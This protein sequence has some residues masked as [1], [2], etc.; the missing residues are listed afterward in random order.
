MCRSS[1]VGNSNDS[2]HV[3]PESGIAADLHTYD[4]AANKWEKF[5]VEAALAELS[6]EEAQVSGDVVKRVHDHQYAFTGVDSMTLGVESLASSAGSPATD[7]KATTAC[8]TPA[9]G[10]TAVRLNLQDTNSSVSRTQ[11]NMHTAHQS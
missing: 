3:T 6:D 2:F 8:E 1:V 7:N 11:A 10:E 9:G 4:K 5:D